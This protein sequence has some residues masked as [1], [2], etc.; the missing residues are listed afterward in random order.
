MHMHASRGS[1]CFGGLPQP[2]EKYS[3]GY[4]ACYYDTLLGEPAGYKYPYD[5]GGIPGKGVV[6]IWTDA[7]D[8][9]PGI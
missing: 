7:F 2:L 6:K 1:G 8:Q 4:I 9:C 3:D 5:S